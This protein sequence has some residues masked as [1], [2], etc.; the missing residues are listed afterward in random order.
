M[1]TS[2]LKKSQPGTLLFLMIYLTFA[3]AAYLILTLSEFNISLLPD[4][5]IK[6][7][8][9][10][11]MMQLFNFIIHK[12]KITATTDFAIFLLTFFILFFPEIFDNPSVI[13]S[14]LFLMLAMRRLLS[15]EKDTNTVRKI[16]DASLWITIASLFYFWSFLYLIPLWLAIF[17]IP[18]RTF[19]HLLMPL[20]GGFL[21]M[22]I[23]IGFLLLRDGS[24][25]WFQTWIETSSFDFSAYNEIGLLVP[26]TIFISFGI[27]IGFYKAFKFSAFSLKEK[28]RQYLQFYIFICSLLLVLLTPQK[29]GAELFFLIPSAAIIAAPYFEEEKSQSYGKERKSEVW[30]KEILLWMFVVISLFFMI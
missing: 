21:I 26:T 20:A 18:N 17:Q 1:L 6:L 2:F 23:A 13:F 30:F 4:I 19:K 7:I 25:D 11:F 15:L 27:W 29:T 10:L 8:A 24:L 22:N 3:Y 14:S 12:N 5:L 16:V 28:S 9:L